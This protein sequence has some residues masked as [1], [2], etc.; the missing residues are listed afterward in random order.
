MGILCPSDV[1]RPQHALKGLIAIIFVLICASTRADERAKN[2]I[3]KVAIRNAAEIPVRLFFPPNGPPY[4]LAII[5]HGSPAR[6]QERPGMEVPSFPSVSEWLTSRGY[7]VALPLRRGYGLSNGLWAENYGPCDHPDYFR[8]GMTSAEDILDV[9]EAL[10]GRD[11]I[12]QDQGLLIGW[13]AG[14]WGTLAAVSLRP[15]GISAAI[16]F[17]GGRGGGQ[18]GV[19]NCKPSHLIEASARFGAT[20]TIPTLWIYSQNDRF[21]SPELSKKMVEAYVSSGGKAEYQLLPAFKEDG[22]NLFVSGEGRAIWQPVVERFL[23]T[24]SQ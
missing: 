18:T 22:H 7:L 6:A 10:R 19:G 8:A 13:S 24:I 1:A 23:A 2:Q 5:N 11:D 4:R 12:I 16:N 14:G 9:L 3:I 17:A 21:F 20:S 15:T